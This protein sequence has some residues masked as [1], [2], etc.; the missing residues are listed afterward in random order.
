[1]SHFFVV[2]R[3]VLWRPLRPFLITFSGLFETA[4]LQYYAISEILQFLV[5][6]IDK[7]A[8]KNWNEE[9]TKNLNR[10]KEFS[11]YYTFFFKNFW[12]ID[13]SFYSRTRI[14]RKIIVITSLMRNDQKVWFWAF[15]SS[16]FLDVIC[17]KVLLGI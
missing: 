7:T 8:S 5:F 6:E 13:E 10:L 1:M 9:K 2:P 12:W 11:S 3:K 16:Q 4:C 15:F 17:R 14:C